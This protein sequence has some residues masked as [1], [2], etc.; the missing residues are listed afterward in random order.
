MQH[1]GPVIKWSLAGISHDD[2][3]KGFSI[4]M[5]NVIGCSFFSF[6]LSWCTIEQKHT[7]PKSAEVFALYVLDGDKEKRCA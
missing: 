1:I 7:P 6:T 4:Y 2:A 3:G 5:I